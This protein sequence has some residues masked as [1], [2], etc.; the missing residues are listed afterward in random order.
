MIFQNIIIECSTLFRSF[1]QTS[2]FVVYEM[3][4]YFYLYGVLINQIS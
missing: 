2:L 4:N 3:H 1:K